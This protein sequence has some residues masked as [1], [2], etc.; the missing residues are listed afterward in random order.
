MGI[1]IKTS[2]GYGIIYGIGYGEVFTSHGNG[3]YVSMKAKTGYTLYITVGAKANFN[4]PSPSPDKYDVV[5][6]SGKTKEW[7]GTDFKEGE[8]IDN[9]LCLKISAY[10]NG[11]LV[12]IQATTEYLIQGLSKDGPSQMVGKFHF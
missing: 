11:K 12:R 1:I 8:L 5:I 2:Y 7:E 6:K 3:S 4:F 10:K 9:N